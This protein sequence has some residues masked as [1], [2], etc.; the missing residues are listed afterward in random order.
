MLKTFSYM[1]RKARAINSSL[2]LELKNALVD[3]RNQNGQP[4]ANFPMTDP[5]ARDPARIL[6][7]AAKLPTGLLD[8]KVR[9]KLHRELKEFDQALA[10]GD[11]LGTL[12]EAADVLYYATK[13]AYIGLLQPVDEGD[14]LF[15]V[16]QKGGFTFP[17]VFDACIK[18]YTLRAAPGNP[19]NDEAE[20]CEVAPIIG[21][22]IES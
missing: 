8:S 16:C 17:Q 3:Y 11:R 7:L 5:L 22:Q 20:R 10:D 4:A 21:I 12:L 1:V 15:Y 9:E 13:A 18:K 14:I 19:K 6:G 2:A